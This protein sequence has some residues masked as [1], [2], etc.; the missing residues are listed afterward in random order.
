MAI[1]SINYQS[2]ASILKT[3]LDKQPLPTTV[4]LELPVDHANVR[5]PGYYH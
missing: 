1:G 4:Q 5:G 3:E 2:I